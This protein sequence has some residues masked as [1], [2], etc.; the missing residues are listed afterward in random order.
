M[1]CSIRIPP[2]ILFSQRRP[3][4]SIQNEAKAPP[5]VNVWA[6]V[7]RRGATRVVIFLAILMATQYVDI[8]KNGLLP[9]L[10]AAYPDDH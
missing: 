3:T 10:E 4:C 5:K 8:L 7:S 2:T 1:H 9:F 6:G